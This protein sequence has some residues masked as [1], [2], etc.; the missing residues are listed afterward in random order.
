MN[1]EWM[2]SM[3]KPITRD[4]A[5]TLMNMAFA[6]LERHTHEDLQMDRDFVLYSGIIG[7][8]MGKHK[9]EADRAKRVAWEIIFN[10][11]QHQLRKKLDAGSS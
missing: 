8:L 7:L 4:E 1:I 3:I 2:S 9:M 10:A 11:N 5:T 6:A